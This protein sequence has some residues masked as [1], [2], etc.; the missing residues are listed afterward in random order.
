[1]ERKGING[2]YKT[3]SENKKR[4]KEFN[5]IRL[6]KFY[7]SLSRK[8][9]IDLIEIIPILITSNQH[10]FPGF[11]PDFEP[12]GMQG[13]QPTNKAINFLL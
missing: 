7:N 2:L 5:N 1:M 10:G 8:E 12:I 3:V 6:Q 4:F 13:F 9:I 11:V